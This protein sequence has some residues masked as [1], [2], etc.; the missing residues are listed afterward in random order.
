MAGGS[1]VGP[2]L[3]ET[4]RRLACLNGDQVLF[5]LVKRQP[6]LHLDKFTGI[7]EGSEKEKK[8]ALNDIVK[9]GGSDEL[10]RQLSLR[11]ANMINTMQAC[12]VE[13]KTAAPLTLHISR[14]GT[15]ENAGICLHPVYGFAYLPGSGIKGLVRSWAET[16]WAQEQKDKEEAWNRIDEL[17]GTGTNSESHKFVSSKRETPGWRPDGIYP[18]E[19]SSAGRLV[20]HDAWPRVWPSLEVDI[21]NNHHT[22]YYGDGKSGPGDWEDPVPVYFLCVR[23]DTLFEFAVS[24]RRPCGDGAIDVASSW[25]QDAL[26][27]M[28][29]GAKTVAG[30]GRFL[31]VGSPKLSV[32]SVPRS[33]EYELRLVSPAFLAGA[34]QNQEDCD[35]RG[36]TLR[37]LLRWWWRAMYAG[38]IDLKDL[39]ILEKSIWG[40]VEI[41]SPISLAVR[42]IA[43]DK[44]HLYDKNEG[45]LHDH[46]I[47]RGS[48]GRRRTTMGLHYTTYGMADGGTNRW[49]M[50]EKARWQVVFTF[51][52]T[53]VN[54]ELKISADE[55]EQ[56]A[57]AALWLLC[58]YGGIGA[59]SRKGFGSLADIEV[60]G[61]DSWKDC[62]KLAEDLAARCR[63]QNSVN[64]MYGP[65]LDTALVEDDI[66]TQW[67]DSWF[68]CHM[69]GE[70]LKAAI[71]SIDKRDRPALGMPRKNADSSRFKD[72][73]HASP[74]FWSLSCKQRG[75]LT[76]RLMAF[77]SSKLPNEEDSTRI[78][79]KFVKDAKDQID[80]RRRN[81]GG[82]AYR[83]CG[84]LESLEDSDAGFT[85][86]FKPT[87]SS[88]RPPTP[89]ELVNVEILE[90]K[91]KK[92]GMKVKHIGSGWDG[93]IIDVPPDGIEPEP[94]QRVE[95]YVN[96]VFKER[97]SIA[98]KWSAPPKK[99]SNKLRRHHSGHSHRRVRRGR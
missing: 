73:R 35:L 82:S 84:P 55:V 30:Y 79:N 23:P 57:L 47:V 58:R 92:G 46:G 88:E 56:Q 68:A 59:K 2:F 60:S 5:P 10:L 67:A 31:A 99:K 36:G 37:G 27:T 48:D 18:K 4:T 15:W 40:S 95:L 7:C 94:G 8:K 34:S 19:S 78:L 26:Q 12:K 50:P 54:P 65:S 43:G 14:A 44:P 61:I 97:K 51:R 22:D 42:R 98:F 77:P 66:D 53:W 63:M 21:T 29:A 85:R 86:N 89:G 20:F 33:R 17:F 13:M 9:I 52:D 76:V 49:Y 11:R 71:K 72:E 39:Q 87:P 1:I 28:G 70:S 80:K 41:G 6:G 91:T 90:E 62:G 24:D 64:E 96:A 93:H 81:P 38:K 75:S 83:S 74:V 3:P 32:P 45:F 16:V 69:I 25:L